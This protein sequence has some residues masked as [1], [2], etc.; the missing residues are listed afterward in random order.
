KENVGRLAAEFQRDTLH[1]ICRLLYD[2]FAYR[3][4]TCKCH[5]VDI[6]MSDDRRT[7]GLTEA[8]H[9]VDDTRRDTDFLEPLRE[10]ENSERGL[11]RRF[12]DAG[13]SSRQCRSQFPC[14][15]KKRVIPRNNLP[16]HTDRLFQRQTHSIVGD[17]VDI[18]EYLCGQAAVILE[19]CRNVVDVEFGFHNRLSSIT[20]FN[21]RQL[22]R[23]LPNLFC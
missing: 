23:I 20:T 22:R 9:Y 17:W 8:R 10:L 13:A 6:G 1:G 19:A 18:P 5:L 11:L 15:H 4:T 14:S 12:Q 3:R 16:R 2:D 21:L 7:T